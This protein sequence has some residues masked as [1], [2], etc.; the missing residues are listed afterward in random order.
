MGFSESIDT[1]LNR[2]ELSLSWSEAP[3]GEDRNL[4]A[5]TEGLDGSVQH[6]D[7]DVLTEVSCGRRV[8]L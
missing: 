4:K 7:R 8:L 1:I 3:G 6:N 2:T 5:E